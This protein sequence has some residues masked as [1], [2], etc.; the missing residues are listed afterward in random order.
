MKLLLPS[1]N[2]ILQLAPEQAKV[3]PFNEPSIAKMDCPAM[4]SMP[5]KESD[6]G[7]IH[8]PLFKL[9][10]CSAALIVAGG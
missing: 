5:L 3:C 2:G 8:Q 4:G 10:F 1:F 6:E 9:Q 7:V